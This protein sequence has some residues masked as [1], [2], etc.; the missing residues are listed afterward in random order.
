MYIKYTKMANYSL[1]TSP[2]TRVL[3]GTK[4]E[5]DAV[6]DAEVRIIVEAVIDVIRHN[7]SNGKS[8][9]KF[10]L[11]SSWNQTGGIDP[12]RMRIVV[13]G[14]VLDH[15]CACEDNF[16]VSLLE[17]TYETGH[18]QFFLVV[19]W[20]PIVSLTDYAR[21]EQIVQ[22]HILRTKQKD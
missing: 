12:D 22:K 3:L 4:E 18:I 9:I 19:K 8:E 1:D 17:E 13:Y 16:S 11:A 14:K 5:A 21:Y 2:P 6:I 15:I 20:E 7:E 10:S